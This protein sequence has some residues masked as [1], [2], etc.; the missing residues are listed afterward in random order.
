M[1]M[2]WSEYWKIWQLCQRLNRLN[3]WS[4]RTATTAKYCKKNWFKPRFKENCSSNNRSTEWSFFLLTVTGSISKKRKKIRLFR[5][6]C[7]SLVFSTVYVRSCD[8]LRGDR[9]QLI[10]TV[11]DRCQSYDR[12]PP[13]LTKHPLPLIINSQSFPSTLGQISSTKKFG[14][15]RCFEFYGLWASPRS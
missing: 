7:W 5:C 15:M 14:A 13:Q 11:S 3:S 1:Q 10:I 4:A 9:D 2:I 6:P 8:W 12:W